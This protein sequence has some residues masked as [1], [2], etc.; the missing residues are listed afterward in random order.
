MLGVWGNP[1]PSWPTPAHRLR[2][3]RLVQLMSAGSDNAMRAGSTRRADRQ[4]PGLHDRPVAEHAL[5][6]SSP[7]PAG[8]T[9]PSRAQLNHEWATD[10]GGLQPEPSPGC[11]PRCAGRT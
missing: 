5:T 10:I 8:C 2:R 9:A 4:R 3:L 11:S 6:L 1:D 7:R